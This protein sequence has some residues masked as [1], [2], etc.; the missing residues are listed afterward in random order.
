MAYKQELSEFCLQHDAVE[1]NSK[2]GVSKLDFDS[3]RRVLALLFAKEEKHMEYFCDLEQ[4][5]QKTLLEGVRMKAVWGERIMMSFFD[6]DAGAV[7]PEHHHPHEQTGYVISGV[8]E[9][10]IGGQQKICKTGDSYIIP[11]NTPHSVNVSADAPARVLD[12]FS[13]PREE[14]K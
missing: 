9:F 14:Y 5:Q 13:P 4:V 1:L 11:S 8:L 12:I 7:I 6:L 10:Q 3:Q 2:A